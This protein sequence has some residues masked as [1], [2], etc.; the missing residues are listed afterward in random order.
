MIMT[1]QALL[2]GMYSIRDLRAQTS[3]PLH[4]RF[5]SRSSSKKSLSFKK[6]SCSYVHKGTNLKPTEST[7]E[8]M[9]N[10]RLAY[11]GGFLGRILFNAFELHRYINTSKLYC[12]CIVVIFI[13]HF[14]DARL[15]FASAPTNASSSGFRQVP[16]SSSSSSGQAPQ[17]LST[18]TKISKTKSTMV[19]DTRAED[20]E[21]LVMGFIGGVLVNLLGW[22]LFASLFGIVAA[23]YVLILVL[24]ILRDRHWPR[25]ASTDASGFQQT[26]TP[27]SRA[28]NSSLSTPADTMGDRAEKGVSSP[29]ENIA[30]DETYVFLME[31]G[32]QA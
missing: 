16:A 14:R 4:S 19:R 12:A 18:H 17:S 15:L 6:F 27:S 26:F 31:E 30:L 3:C 10:S 22:R 13:R 11:L 32:I 20:R 24:L 2:E 28:Q 7:R 23:G 5:P 29:R 8:T 25:N 1:S 21:S 9:G